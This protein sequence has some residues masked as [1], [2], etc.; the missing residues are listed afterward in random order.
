[1][2]TSTR[3]LF[4]FL[5]TL[6][7]L[8]LP[9][10][11][12]N[13]QEAAPPPD[14]LDVSTPPPPIAFGIEGGLG[15]LGDE[16]Q[17]FVPEEEKEE[18]LQG[19]EDLNDDNDSRND[20]QNGESNDNGYEDD[21]NNEEP[22]PA[23]AKPVDKMVPA[24]VAGGAACGAAVGLAVTGAVCGPLCLA[25]TGPV[26]AAALGGGGAFFGTL[27]GEIPFDEALMPILIA[28]GG[29]AAVTFLIGGVA[30]G[31]SIGIGA[32]F[33]IT[34]LNALLVG[35]SVAG[36]AGV[37]A[38]AATIGIVVGSLFLFLPDE[39]GGAGTT[40]EPQVV[41]ALVPDAGLSASRQ[42]TSKSSAMAF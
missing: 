3:C 26:T 40:N 12:T 42:P 4:P 9:P 34:G 19:E 35:L 39:I 37:L 8:G 30:T 24:M 1:M 33:Q 7:F 25:C 28:A 18:P 16:D 10:S 38:G 23:K 13:A 21:G 11:T 5:C 29:P 22:K 6:F 2:F 17:D 27:F 36:A 32:A 20:P 41:Q 15:T 31:I 14:E